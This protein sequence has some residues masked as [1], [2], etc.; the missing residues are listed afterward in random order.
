MTY[1]EWSAIM[2]V[3]IAP[4]PKCSACNLERKLTLSV[5]ITDD[6]V[7]NSFECPNCK[8][9]LRVAEWQDSEQGSA[10]H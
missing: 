4:T 9:T 10:G 7:I 1:S 5:P 3:A 6:Y 2:V 8:T